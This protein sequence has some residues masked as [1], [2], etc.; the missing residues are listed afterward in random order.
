ML[1]AV[2]EYKNSVKNN[3]YG[4]FTEIQMFREKKGYELV[5]L[6]GRE[7]KDYKIGTKKYAERNKKA[8]IS[9]HKIE[10]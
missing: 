2:A 7:N 9:P 6:Q 5:I 8:V 3:G 1:K 4:G 10:E